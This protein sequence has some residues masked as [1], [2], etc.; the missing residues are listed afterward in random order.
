MSFKDFLIEGA[1]TPDDW[2]KIA[3]NKGFKFKEADNSS[4]PAIIITG[5]DGEH[6]VKVVSMEKAKRYIADGFKSKRFK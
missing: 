1:R 5:P 6:I 4:D 3:L 2:Y